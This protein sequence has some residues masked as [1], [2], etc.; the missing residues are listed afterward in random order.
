MP[1]PVPAQPSGTASSRRLVRVPVP[2]G[3]AGVQRVLEALPA[4]LDGTGPA[5]APIPVVSASVSDDYVRGVLTALRPEDPHLPLES[6]DV[7]AV[8]STSGST[9][10]PRGV[11]LSAQA[12]TATSRSVNGDGSPQWIVALPVTSIGGLQ[13]LVRSLAADRTPV[14]LPSVGGAEPFAPQVFATAIHVAAAR[15]RD[16]RVS[17]VPAQVARILS[18]PAASE[19][20]ASCSQVLVGGGPLRA[21]LRAMAAAV[22][23]TLTPTYGA[24]ETSGGCVYD[25]RP[26]PGVAVGIEGDEPSAPGII[27][28]GGSTIALGYRGDEAATARHFITRG[29]QR[30][31]RTPDLGRMLADGTLEVLGRADDVVV[32]NGINV[33]PDAVERVI[34]DLPDIEAA[35]VVAVQPSDGEPWLAAFVQVRDD[36]P[37]IEDVL[38]DAVAARLGPVARPRAVRTVDRLPHLPNGKVD[39]RLLLEWA[40]RAT[41]D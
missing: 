4:A 32:V 27:E 3:P 16:V 33:S 19:A 36:A 5:I 35:A 24:T 17:V 1:R 30:V 20:L 39:R 31:F 8:V 26:L 41:E 29:G 11:L 15:S 2:A 23:I 38:R 28:V 37:R 6:D 40:T 34:G 21:S 14:V 22:G 12:L 25:G 9:G 7:A 10:A 18:D 13:V